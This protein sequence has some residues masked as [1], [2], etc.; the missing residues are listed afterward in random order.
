MQTSDESIQL[1]HDVLLFAEE[2]GFARPIAT[3]FNE[4]ALQ[5]LTEAGELEA[6]TAGVASRKSMQVSGVDWDEEREVLTCITSSFAGENELGLSQE[7]FLEL[8]TR[9]TEFAD[10][11]Q[12]VAGKVKVAL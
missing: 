8:L 7:S 5:I 9:L 11:P 3:L 1:N 2:D 4:F 10:W 12:E 6:P